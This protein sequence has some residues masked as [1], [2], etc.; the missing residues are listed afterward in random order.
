MLNIWYETAE[1]KT[2]NLPIVKLYSSTKIYNFSKLTA[3]YLCNMN[4]TWVNCSKQLNVVNFST[5]I[6]YIYIYI[7]MYICI[8]IYIYIDR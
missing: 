2:K 3:T 5:L 4:F 1:G 8:Y 7:Y 6:L